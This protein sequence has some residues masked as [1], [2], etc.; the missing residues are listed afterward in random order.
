MSEKLIDRVEKAET[1]AQE[2]E[3]RANARCDEILREAHEKAAG[4]TATMLNQAKQDAQKVVAQAGSESETFESGAREKRKTQINSMRQA[5]LQREN[6][7]VQLVLSELF[8]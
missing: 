8:E 3:Q 2:A 5:A 4:E 6:E 1:D 7:A